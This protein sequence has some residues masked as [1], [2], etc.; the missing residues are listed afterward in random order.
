MVG[1]TREA[2]GRHLKRFEREGWIEVAYG[3]LVVLSRAG[4][5][6]LL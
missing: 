1:A 3:R 2:V 4:L 5:A 6:S